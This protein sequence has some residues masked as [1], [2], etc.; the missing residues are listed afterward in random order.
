[1]LGAIPNTSQTKLVMSETHGFFKSGST[2]NNLLAIWQYR[3]QPT[4]NLT[5]PP[6]TYWQSGSTCNNR[7][8]IWKYPQQNTGNLTNANHPLLPAKLNLPI[9]PNPH[10]SL[11]HLPAI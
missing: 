3:Q 11:L 8:A 10:T 5:V 4:G 2:P 7:Q 1:M 9:Q 6:T